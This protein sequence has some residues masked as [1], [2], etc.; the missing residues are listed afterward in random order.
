MMHVHLVE[1]HVRV[2]DLLA[3]SSDPYTKIRMVKTKE[4]HKSGCIKKTLHPVWN[5]QFTFECKDTDDQVEFKVYDK[6]FGL[7]KDDFLGTATITLQDLLGSTKGFSGWKPLMN[8]KGESQGTIYITIVLDDVHRGELQKK[9]H[10]VFEKMRST[11]LHNT[12]KAWRDMLEEKDSEDLKVCIGT[13]NVGNAPPHPYQ[14]FSHW[15]KPDQDIYVIGVQECKYK[16]PKSDKDATSSS[17]QAKSRELGDNR[18]EKKEEDEE[19]DSGDLSWNATLDDFFKSIGNYKL[20]AKEKLEQIKMHCYV[21]QEL[22]DEIHHV[23][24]GTEATGIGG[25]YGNKGGTAVAFYL[26]TM[27]FCFINSHM[28]AHQDKTAQRNSDFKNIVKGLRHLGGDYV[29]ALH[30]FHHVF[31][32]GD[33]NYRLDY[34]DQG[35]KKTPDK[36]QF[37]DMVQMI[38]DGKYEEMFQYDQLAREMNS[39]RVFFGFQEGVYDFKPTFKRLRGPEEGYTQQRSPAYCDRILWR[40]YPGYD[41]KQ[42]ELDSV[43]K[44]TTSD[45]KPVYSIFNIAKQPLACAID[46]SRTACTIKITNLKGKGLMAQDIGGTSDPY[47]IFLGDILEKAVKTATKSKT[48]NPAW[49]NRE[50]PVLK[51]VNSTTRL[52]QSSLII[53]VMDHD[54]ASTNE[55]MGYGL[56]PLQAFVAGEAPEGF[57]ILV[58]K[59]GL[60]QGSLTGML[61][62]C[63]DT[64][65]KLMTEDEMKKLDP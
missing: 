25:V 6:D 35:D 36:D 22:I 47:L 53:K 3:H 30:Q 10:K 55:C 56:L 21:R 2:A 26:G 24:T 7:Q 42:M 9:N 34:G 11:L 19:L 45:H 63:W 57:G 65:Q 18:D 52:A 50:V 29:D 44:F 38:D 15:F 51:L 60:P 1:A 59:D 32:M 4:K 40:T 5:E 39:C 61:E 58:K 64:P 49:E 16:L 62:I 48:L 20:I 28:A 13:W 12:M 27:S 17:A 23:S 31:W 43:E 8:E 41:I 37:D 33:L 14:H 46:L 54:V